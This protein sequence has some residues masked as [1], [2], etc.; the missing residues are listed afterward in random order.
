MINEAFVQMQTL[1]N[2]ELADGRYA[3]GLGDYIQLQDA[4][5]NYN[6]AQV[7]YVQTVY[8]YNR[9]IIFSFAQ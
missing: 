2:F 8:N 4:K 3:V 5:V 6:N 9:V 7:S 1:E